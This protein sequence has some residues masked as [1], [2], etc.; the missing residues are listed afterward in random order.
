M[1]GERSINGSL[2]VNKELSYS[3]ELNSIGIVSLVD[4]AFEKGKEN[5][6][7]VQMGD[8]ENLDGEFATYAL[9]KNI[10]NA[11]LTLLSKKYAGRM[12]IYNIVLGNMFTG[13][14]AGSPEIKMK[15]YTLNT[16]TKKG[17]SSSELAQLVDNILSGNLISLSGNKIRLTSG[18]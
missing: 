11:T 4:N 18:L 6:F 2:Q 8:S 1:F 16:V 14:T 5:T 17:V 7:L 15:R 12:E 9:G 3:V 13:L 10:L